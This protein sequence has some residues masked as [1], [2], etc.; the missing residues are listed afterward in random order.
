[1]SEAPQQ[2]VPIRKAEQRA[3]L[4]NP[5]SSLF[6]LGA[7]RTVVL[8]T[9]ADAFALVPEEILW[10]GRQLD[11]VFAPLLTRTPTSVPLSV[12]HEMFEGKFAAAL[13]RLETT[14]PITAV[15][16]ADAPAIGARAEDW[17]MVTVQMVGECYDLTLLEETTMHGQIVGMLRDLGIDHP[18]RPRAARYLPNNVKY[19]L[20]HA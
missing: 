8:C 16:A 11:G 2:V 6:C 1:M 12:R 9:F 3:V 7:L 13:E 10:T 18:T 19:R 15:A 14:A 17:A 20:N 4:S 5:D